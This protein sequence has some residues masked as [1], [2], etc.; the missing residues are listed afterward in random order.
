MNQVV[1]LLVVLIMLAAVGLGG[2]FYLAQAV[3]PSAQPVE[4]VLRD[5]QFP[6]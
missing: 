4:K 3:E 5:D 2:I 6:R 1:R